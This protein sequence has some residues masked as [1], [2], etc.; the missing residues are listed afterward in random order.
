[1]TTYQTSLEAI[2]RVNYAMSVPLWADS[3]LVIPLDSNPIAKLPSFI[4]YKVT[5][6][7]ISAEDL[8]IELGTDL[9]Q[10]KYYNEIKQGEELKAGQWLIIPRAASE[11]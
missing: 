2:L 10:L 5:A 1:M 8:A 4:P 11:K 9:K 7:S 6:G 3:Y